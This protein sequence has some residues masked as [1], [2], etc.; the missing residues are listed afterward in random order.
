LIG[1]RHFIS[2]A[3]HILDVQGIFLWRGTS[4]R[5]QRTGR[6]ALFFEGAKTVGDTVYCPVVTKRENVV[7]ESL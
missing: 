3:L 6:S 5:V 4:A 7:D 2:N 1:T